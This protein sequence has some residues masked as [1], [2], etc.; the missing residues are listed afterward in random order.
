MI[1]LVIALLGVPTYLL[2]KR[3]TSP[4]RIDWSILNDSEFAQLKPYLIA[5]AKVESADFQSEIFKKY[6]N[7]FGMGCPRKRPTTQ[8]GCSE[9]NYDGG[10]RVGIY[11]SP[12]ESLRDQILWLRYTRFPKEVYSTEEFAEQ[13]KKRSYFQTDTLTYIKA[14]ESWLLQ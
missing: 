6:N 10:R 8:T 13:M 1:I 9:P 12:N 3:R 14:L 4:G 2:V 5:Q 11:S 7:A